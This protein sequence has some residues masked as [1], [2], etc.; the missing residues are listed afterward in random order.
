MERETGDWILYGELVRAG[1][2]L[3]QLHLVIVWRA[4][5]VNVSSGWMRM[6]EVMVVK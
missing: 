2:R 3:N 5:I 1:L 6:S 4:G